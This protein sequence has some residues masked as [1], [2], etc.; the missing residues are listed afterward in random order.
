[1]HILNL[2][3]PATNELKYRYADRYD[4]ANDTKSTHQSLILT[5]HDKYLSTNLLSDIVGRVSVT[6]VDVVG[7]IY[8]FPVIVSGLVKPEKS[9]CVTFIELPALFNNDDIMDAN[10]Q[11]EKKMFDNALMYFEWN[12]LQRPASPAFRSPFG[13]TMGWS[14]PSAPRN[15]QVGE[16]F[17]QPSGPSFRFLAIYSPLD[18]LSLGWFDHGVV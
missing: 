10:L 17:F 7:R 12:S 13:R 9:Q 8:G 6:D 3:I 5:T 16:K 2:S 15:F 4:C 14:A 18:G 1:M 11:L